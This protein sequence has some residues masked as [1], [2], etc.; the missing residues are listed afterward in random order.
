MAS[1]KYPRIA[2]LKT[3]ADFRNHL[4][5]SGIALGFDDEL[6]RPPG[7]PLA[8]PHELGGVKVGNRF[9]ILPMEGWDGMSDGTPSEL[10]R[11]RWRHFGTSGAKLIWGGEA[12]AVRHDGRA[13]PAQLLLT[14]RTVAAIASLREE[15]ISVHCSRFGANAGGDLLIGLQLTHSGRFSRPDPP[16]TPVPLAGCA[17]PLLDR[18]FA[19]GVRVLTDDELDRLVDDFI[20]AAKL[21]ATAG[22]QFVDIKQCHGYLG[23]ELLGAKN[24]QGR[25]G[26]SFENRTRFL[27]Q[28]VEGIHAAVPSLTIGVRLSAFDVVPHRKGEGGVGVPEGAPGDAQ[29][30][31]GVLADE[32]LDDALKECRA[33]L[34]ALE[35]LNVRWVCITAGSPYYSPHIQRPAFFPPMDGYQ[36]PEDPLRGVARQIRA[37]AS[38]K[39]AFPGMVFVG[40]AYS[41]LQEWL[42]YVAQYNVRNMLTDFVGLGRIVLSYPGL[43]GD[44]L[45][46]APIQRRHI[47][48][49][50][51]DCTTGPR[52]GFVSGC[53]PL[54]S[55]Y[56]ARP[57][58][59]QIQSVRTE[60]TVHH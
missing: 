26:G 8:E 33:V 36:P 19:G 20:A 15:L 34:S 10:T 41:Y 50:F 30:G 48:R 24:R 29:A 39:S 17:H 23:H 25:Y 31:F 53:F 49:T 2:A 13:N 11:R 9:C 3:A 43:A 32:N 40:S 56:T 6:T 22:F 21:A 38:L 14:P 27:R 1:D 52:M 44:V 4:Q 60:S 42:P 47:C 59:K 55:F 46:G 28:V 12:V 37:T 18:R 51:S 16:G 57:E 7:S 54:D 5:R 45:S 58:S 35:N